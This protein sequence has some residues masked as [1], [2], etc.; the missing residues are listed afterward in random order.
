MKIILQ[1]IIAGSG[2]SSRRK[3]EEL[4]RQGQVQ[5]NGRLAFAG[6]QA[7]PEKDQITVKGRLIDDQPKKIYIKLNKPLNYTCTNRSFPGEKNIFDLVDIPERLFAVGR[8]D[9]DSRGL[10]LLTNDGELTQRLAH[11]RFEHDKVY[12]VKIKENIKNAG[13]IIKKFKEGINIGEDGIVRAKD[14]KH[15]QKQIFIITLNSGKKRQIRLMFNALSLSVIDLKRINFA[16]LELADLPE[17][18]WTYL[19][20]EEINNLTRP[21]AK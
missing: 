9:K 6:D 20:P 5:V 2:Y 18:R 16:G 11:P 21:S 1:K 4:I 12:E 14:I 7:D 17:G 15:L 13:E 3:A 8:L 19:S 10:L